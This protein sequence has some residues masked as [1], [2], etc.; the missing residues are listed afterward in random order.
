[1][2]GTF[3][4]RGLI[5]SLPGVRSINLQLHA[6]DRGKCVHFS[7]F[8]AFIFGV[9]LLYHEKFLIEIAPT[10]ASVIKY[11]TPSRRIEVADVKS[12]YFFFL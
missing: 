3:F 5:H 12:A 8:L 9:P 4:I 6:L 7:S 2:P 1:M 10:S 11:Y